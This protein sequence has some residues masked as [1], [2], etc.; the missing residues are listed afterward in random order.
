MNEKNINI[1]L[2]NQI[3]YAYLLFIT[4]FNF[5]LLILSPLFIN[6]TFEL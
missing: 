1:R 5:I 6:K 4:T 3:I 2:S